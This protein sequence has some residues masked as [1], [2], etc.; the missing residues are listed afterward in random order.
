MVNIIMI[1]INW[2]ASGEYY[3]Y[4]EGLGPLWIN[5]INYS[6]GLRELASIHKWDNRI[7]TANGYLYGPKVTDGIFYE[8]DY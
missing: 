1:K 2:R 4:I 7:Y 5:Y 6:D 3:G 8:W